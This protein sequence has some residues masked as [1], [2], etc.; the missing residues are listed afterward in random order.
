M[1]MTFPGFLPSMNLGFG[2]WLAAVILDRGILLWSVVERFMKSANFP[3][4]VLYDDSFTT[5]SGKSTS[6]VGRDFVS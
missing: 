6:L 2:N 4:G 3:H 1:K 5:C